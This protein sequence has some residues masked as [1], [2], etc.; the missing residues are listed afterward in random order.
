M[1]SFLRIK[2]DK[3]LH[4]KRK[5]RSMVPNR[6]QTLEIPSGGNLVNLYKGTLSNEERARGFGPDQDG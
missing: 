2:F 4:G 6:R 3:R 5:I 1:I